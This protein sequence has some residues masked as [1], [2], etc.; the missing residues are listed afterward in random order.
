VG[1]NGAS[2]DALIA[3]HWPSKEHRNEAAMQVVVFLDAAER[4]RWQLHSSDGLAVAEGCDAFAT[5]SQ[6]V[7]NANEVCRGIPDAPVEVEV[8]TA[9]SW[10]GSTARINETFA[11]VCQALADRGLEDALEILNRPLLHR[12]SAIYWMPDPERLVNVAVFD[13]L[14]EAYPPHLQWV[15]YNQS[16]CQFAIREGQ[17]RT[18]NSALDARLDGHAY[19]G[20]LNS[21]HAV[22]LVS[23]GGEILGTICH[24]DAASLALDDDDFELLRMVARVVVHHLPK[25]APPAVREAAPPLAPTGSGNG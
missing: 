15:P 11:E 6:A 3:G 22:P 23:T 12:Y 1:S 18:A 8:P 24:F 25:P 20:V 13:K 17:F 5:Y 21:Y 14:G 16:F 2:F 7:R 10:V 9:S 19:Q 4:W